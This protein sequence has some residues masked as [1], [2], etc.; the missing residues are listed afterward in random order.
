VITR[1]AAPL[2]DIECDSD[3]FA[4]WFFVEMF[5]LKVSLKSASLNSEEGVEGEYENHRSAARQ[6][7]HSRRLDLGD[8]E[9]CNLV[10]VENSGPVDAY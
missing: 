10:V 5:H 8:E 6:R 9:P 1:R 7:A 3:P 4:H 2:N